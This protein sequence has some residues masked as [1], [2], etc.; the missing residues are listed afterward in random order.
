M[1]KRKR[2]VPDDRLFTDLPKIDPP[3]RK[4]ERRTDPGFDGLYAK[5]GW[6]PGRSWP[7]PRSAA[8]PLVF[9]V[10]LP[11]VAFQLLEVSGQEE[12]S[13]ICS[14]APAEIVQ[15]AADLDQAVGAAGI[16]VRGV[17]HGQ[18]EDVA[19]GE[20]RVVLVVAFSEADGA[21]TVENLTRPQQRANSSTSAEKV[22]DRA[23]LIT[24][25]TRE[26]DDEHGQPVVTLMEQ[27]L[28]QSQFGPLVMAFSTADQAM[29]TPWGRKLYEQIVE[30]SSIWDESGS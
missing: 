16:V 12:L 13:A 30:T 15:G 8:P 22:S 19:G 21:L 9:T 3:V 25:V 4:G 23:T 27:Y 6:G 17:M 28:L 14:P 1:W 29:I 10:R 18:R 11:V 20:F 5:H 26:P 24:H 7:V 2:G